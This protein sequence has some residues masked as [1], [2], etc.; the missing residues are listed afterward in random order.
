[1][2]GTPGY[3]SPEQWMTLPDVDGR[4]DI[5][6]LGVILYECVTGKLPFGGNTPYE[7]LQAHLNHPVPDPCACGAEPALAQVILRMLA[8]RREQRQQ[9]MTE[10][11]RELQ[12]LRAAPSRAHAATI[13][14][15]R[16]SVARAT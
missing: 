4:A 5:Y 3:M 9:N 2:I 15:P 13:T 7:W 12:A 11:M 16:P 8:K 14:Q 1:M 10:V 6:A